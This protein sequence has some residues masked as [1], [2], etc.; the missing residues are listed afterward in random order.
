MTIQELFRDHGVEFASSGE[1]HHARS[2]WLAI[3]VCPFCNSGNYHLGWN[4]RKGYFN[5]WSCRGHRTIVTLLKLGVPY[6]QA[7]AFSKDRELL[8][9]EEKV[10]RLK[11]V[12]PPYRGPLLKIH[13]E[14]LLGRRFSPEELEKV[15]EIEG[16]GRYGGKRGLAWRIYIPINYK[17]RRVSWTTRAVSDTVRERYISATAQ[18]ESINHKEILYGLDFVGHSVIAVEGPTDAWNIGPGAVGTF[19]LAYSPAQVLL[20]SRIPY[21]YICFDST[22]AAQKRAEEL[23]TELAPFP[24]ETHVVELDAEDPGS[25]TKKEVRLLRKMAKMD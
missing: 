24:G 5:C 14:Y 13:R 1:H 6:V 15:W 2:N 16:F 12:E 20:L 4:L 19:G 8:P 7:Q 25:A 21:R 23:A 11:L 9:G 3:R 17:E 18:E 22:P 10:A